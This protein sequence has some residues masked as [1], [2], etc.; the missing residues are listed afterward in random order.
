MQ[1]PNEMRITGIHKDYDVTD[2]LG[3][4]SVP[5]LFVCGRRHGS[6]RSEETA[7]YHSLVPDAEPEE[8]LQALR[9]FVPRHPS[10]PLLSF[11]S[12]GDR[13]RGSYLQ[14]CLPQA[15]LQL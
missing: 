12:E 1:G 4:L 11:T 14:L 15:S 8:Y 6:T 13:R 7:W 3:Q 5:T 10:E 2:R 9:G